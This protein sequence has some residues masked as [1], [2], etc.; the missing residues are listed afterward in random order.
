MLEDSQENNRGALTKD[1]VMLEMFPGKPIAT[2]R[3]A[4]RS[5]IQQLSLDALIPNLSLTATGHIG[6]EI[7]A[8]ANKHGLGF[9]LAASFSHQIPVRARNGSP[10]KASSNCDM[11]RCKFLDDPRDKNS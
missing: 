11:V 3:K 5:E 7:N 8:W 4:S 6:H 9:K 1:M 2:Q 10:R